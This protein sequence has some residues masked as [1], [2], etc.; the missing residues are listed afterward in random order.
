MTRRS[1]P[2][3]SSGVA[4][5]AHLIGKDDDC[6]AFTARAHQIFLDRGDREAAARA[7][8]WL[9]FALLARGAMAPASGW[10]AR[11]ERLLDEG[12]LDCVVRGY[13]LIPTAIQH[14]VQGDASGALATFTQAAEIARRFGD[15]D[16]ASSPFTDVGARSYALD[17][18]EGRRAAR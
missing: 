2:K 11:A 8:F 15:R 18:F 3:T 7:A 16:L 12:Q 5:A 13:L 6:E 4:I 10:L 14:V 9:G 1:T 17:T